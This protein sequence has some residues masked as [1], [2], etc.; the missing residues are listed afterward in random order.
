MAH[1]HHHHHLLLPLILVQILFLILPSSSH[2]ATQAIFSQPLQLL[3]GGQSLTNGDLTLSLSNNCGLILY[4]A[5]IPV[6]DFNTS[7]TTSYCALFVSEEGQL[8]L[9]AD[10]ERTPT[11]T[12]GKKTY[13]GR[14]ALLFIDGKL[15]IFG[16]AIWNNGVTPTTFFDIN[17]LSLGLNH[18][19]LKTAGS[20]DYILFSGNIANGSANGDVV[21]AQNGKVSTVITKKCAL[22]VKDDTGKTIWSTWPTSAEPTQCFLELTSH[23]ELLLQWYNE[24][25]VYTQWKG[26]YTA[27]ENL[28][29]CL[30]R[31]FGRIAIYGLKTWLYQDGS[32]SSSAGA[33]ATV[34]A[35]KIKMV[36]A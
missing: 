17:K 23:G 33:V 4:K 12:I 16:P 11:Q 26:G 10:N 2:A 1:H 24:S 13:S 14:Y 30:L 25:G 8:L 6:L 20:T 29:V 32:S 27:R 31:Y 22:A 18:E 15:G 28:Y 7:T 5:S 35:E 36:T 9:V 3:F 19:K 34:V 21:I